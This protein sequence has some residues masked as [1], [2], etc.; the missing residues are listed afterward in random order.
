MSLA[1]FLAMAKNP[2]ASGAEGL[3]AILAQLG[4]RANR[5]NVTRGIQ[6]D[7]PYSSK[8]AGEAPFASDA[9][10]YFA[11]ATRQGP[12]GSLQSI[13]EKLSSGAGDAAAF[14]RRRPVA[15]NATAA[16]VPGG[17]LALLMGDDQ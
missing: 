14:A 12:E 13:L 9:D 17:L 2:V 8:M 11:E 4:K 1:R 6:M 3:E 5:T 15:S 16:A 7:M 10:S